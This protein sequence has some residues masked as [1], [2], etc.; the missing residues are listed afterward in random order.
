MIAPCLVQ[1][2]DAYYSSVVMR[3]LHERGIT[4][5]VGIHDCWMVPET[6]QTVV[7]GETKISKGLDVLKEVMF[8]ADD[9]WYDG[10]GPV[11]DDL[12]SY[13]GDDGDYRKL[14]SSARDKWE[15]RKGKGSPPHF[16]AFEE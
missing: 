9:E 10:L 8:E 3:K 7:G 6:V 12:L 1:V 5:F 2:L 15:R 13:L 4:S 16:R 14:I 11:Y